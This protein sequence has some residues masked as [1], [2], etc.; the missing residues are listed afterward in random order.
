[1][2]GLETFIK[3]IPFSLVE[4]LLKP[5]SDI[6]KLCRCLQFNYIIVC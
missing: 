6:K 3:I 5:K 1:M 2:V 4:E